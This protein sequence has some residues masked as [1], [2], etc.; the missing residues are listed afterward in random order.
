MGTI[1]HTHSLGHPVPPAALPFLF[2]HILPHS[3]PSCFNS[4][5]AVPPAPITL[6]PAT[7]SKTRAPEQDQ[8]LLVPSSRSR[9]R[10]RRYSSGVFSCARARKPMGTGRVTTDAMKLL[11]WKCLTLGVCIPGKRREKANFPLSC[12]R[13]EGKHNFHLQRTVTRLDFSK[14]A[15]I[16]LASAGS[17]EV[18]SQ[19]LP[20]FSSCKVFSAPVP[21]PGPSSQH[22]AGSPFHCL[23]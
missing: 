11:I 7:T 4:I 2:F 5:L 10:L 19:L 13:Q 1:P 20:P 9:L 14:P 18:A 15:L 21:T 6:S 3:P 12:A 17:G 8:G 23:P 16:S 22:G